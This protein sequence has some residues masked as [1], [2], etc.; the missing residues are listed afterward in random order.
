[1]D[2]AIDLVSTLHQRE[3]N[4]G[5]DDSVFLNLDF[6]NTPPRTAAEIAFVSS[7]LQYTRTEYK[8]W[9]KAEPP[10]TNVLSS[11]ADQYREIQAHLELRWPNA[12]KPPVKLRTLG[13][14]S[15]GL[16]Q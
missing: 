1:M 16:D 8:V 9:M 12:Y 5:T 4:T 2:Y 6:R 7:A 14:V 15:G 11:Y 3:F 13:P 10:L